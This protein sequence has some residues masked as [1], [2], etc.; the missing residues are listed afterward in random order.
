MHEGRVAADERCIDDGIPVTTVARTLLDLASVLEP[1]RLRQAVSKAEARQL[2]DVV[3]LPMLLERHRGR[4]GIAVLREIL[5]DRRFGRD[6][7]RSDLEI[8]FQTFLRERA[9]ARPEINARLEVGGRHL[10]VDCIW[11]EL[12]VIVELDSRRHHA[13]WDASEADRA[14]DRILIA[15]GYAPLRVTWKAL[16]LDPDRLEDE[17]RAALSRRAA[18]LPP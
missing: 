4:R 3:S 16:H 14:R 5:E 9:F 6:V 7:T 12:G 2:T 17:L 8:D 15:A 1:E 13:G 11:R 10:E 18:G